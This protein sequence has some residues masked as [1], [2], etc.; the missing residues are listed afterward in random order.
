MWEQHVAWIQDLVFVGS[1]G[2]R[3]AHT[4][5]V[6]CRAWVA[7]WTL[8]LGLHSLSPLDVVPTYSLLLLT[9]SNEAATKTLYM[10]CIGKLVDF[11]HVHQ[12]SRGM[13]LGRAKGE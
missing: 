9:L 1:I 13:C 7:V 4:L 12:S 6:A 10:H 3:S 2:I 5:E 11:A 8:C